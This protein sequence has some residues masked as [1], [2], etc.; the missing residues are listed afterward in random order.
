[1]CDFGEEISSYHL[2]YNEPKYGYRAW[3]LFNNRLESMYAMYVWESGINPLATDDGIF[4]KKKNVKNCN[5]VGYHSF[6]ELKDVREKY[7]C[8]GTF[9]TVVYGRIAMWG[10]IVEHE[11]GYRAEYAKIVEISLIY[12][13]WTSFIRRIKNFFKNPLNKI[14]ITYNV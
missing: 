14:R 9:K 1:M 6:K 10:D 3:C 13:H 7:D 12:I 4:E 2:N 8:Y 5:L 11:N